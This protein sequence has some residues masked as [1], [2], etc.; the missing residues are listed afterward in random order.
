VLLPQLSYETVDPEDD[1]TD[2]ARCM[3]GTER[4]E[5]QGELSAEEAI[6][7]GGLPNAPFCS[8]WRA[9]SDAVRPEAN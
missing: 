6:C 1:G 7:S 5:E 4:V 8:C 2:V 9:R 3:L